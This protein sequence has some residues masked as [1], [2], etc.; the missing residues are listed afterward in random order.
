MGTT[1]RPAP[2]PQGA[3]VTSVVRYRKR[4]ALGLRI[5]RK[6]APRLA[7]LF[8]PA[9]CVHC[10]GDRW[11]ATPLCLACLKKAAPLRPPLGAKAGSSGAD[12]EPGLTGRAIAD[13]G[14]GDGATVDGREEAA[15]GAR[16]AM[17]LRCLFNMGPQLS[18][19]IHGFKYRHMRRH[20]RFLCAYLRYRPDLAEWAGGFDALVPVPIHAVRRRERGYNQAMEI[21]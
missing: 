15:E 6:A 5:L 12:S 13:F 17:P 20:I 4:Y 8:M 9:L 16:E 21:A 10:G 3:G 11:G 19:L 7:A 18:T 14:N 2:E 1:F